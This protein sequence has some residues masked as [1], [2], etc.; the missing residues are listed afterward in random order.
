MSA[1]RGMMVCWGGEPPNHPTY[2][3]PTLS[4]LQNIAV[5]PHNLEAER[6]VLGA[7]LIDDRHLNTLVVEEQL[8][9][10]HFYRE[11]HGLVFA[12]MIEFYQGNRKIDHL[13]VA[14]VLRQNGKLDQVGGE[15]AIEQLAGWVPAAGHA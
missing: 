8:R 6:S 5:P 14:E 4:A 10:D 2:I 9:A 1:G 11:E 15:E 7:V 3:R 13:T 12:A